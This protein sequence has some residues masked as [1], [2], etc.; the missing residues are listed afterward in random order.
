MDISKKE[1]AGIRF[2]NQFLL[3]EKYEA[4]YVNLSAK[5]TKNSTYLK[6]LK[7]RIDNL[8]NSLKRPNEILIKYRELTKKVKRD[9]GILNN[10]EKQLGLFKLEKAK[11]IDPWEIISIPTIEGKVFPK[12][13]QTAIIYFIL[14]FL[15]SS[16]VQF[17]RE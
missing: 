9:E 10:V 17:F 12:R 5:L 7:L 3:L 6:N 16:L 1:N 11:Q 15:F 4:E 2:R 8:R 14:S 13:S